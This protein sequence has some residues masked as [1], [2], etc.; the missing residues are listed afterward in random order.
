MRL[1]LQESF[2]NRG[3]RFILLMLSKASAGWM[4]GADFGVATIGCSGIRAARQ[5]GAGRGTWGACY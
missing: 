2:L 5:L 3:S 1:P 4:M